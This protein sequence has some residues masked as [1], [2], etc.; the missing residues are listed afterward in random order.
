MA[1]DVGLSQALSYARDLKTLFEA[2]QVREQELLRANDRLR[3]AYRGALASAAELK[4][5]RRRLQRSF[6]QSLLG[7]ANA[8]EAKDVYTRGHAERVAGLARQLARAAGLGPAAAETVAQ[9]GLLHDLGKIGVPEAV[10]TK[11]GPLTPEEWAL[12]RLHPI[13]GAQI[14]MPLEFFDEGAV[15][16]RYHHER[17]DGSGYPDGLSG[18]MIPI[19]ARIVAVADVYDALASDRPYRPAMSPAEIERQLRAEAGRTLDADL[20]DLLLRI[21]DGP[22]DDPV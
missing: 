15:I 13:T 18:D 6:F 12:M 8:I 22:L 20:T 11:R 10:L 5:S 2:S 19:G 3:E 9:A 4:R 7:L 14:L 17:L 16:V 21:V 1:G